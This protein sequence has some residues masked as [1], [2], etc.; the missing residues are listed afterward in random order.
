[1]WINFTL[2]AIK[3]VESIF[4]HF[5]SNL[6]YKLQL[7]VCLCLSKENNFICVHKTVHKSYHKLKELIIMEVGSKILH[8]LSLFSLLL[9]LVSAVA[10]NDVTRSRIAV[11]EY[12]EPLSKPTKPPSTFS[13]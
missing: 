1:M 2:S 5:Q 13:R 8:F 12:L 10:S 6:E 9:S 11:I 3:N 4:R 7:H